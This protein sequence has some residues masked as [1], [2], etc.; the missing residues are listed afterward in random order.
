MILAIKNHKYHITCPNCGALL[1]F[2]KEDMIELPN[3]GC[4]GQEK[5]YYIVC[6]DCK[7]KQIV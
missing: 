3:S 1:L 4:Y 2:G 6:P 7:D 5:V